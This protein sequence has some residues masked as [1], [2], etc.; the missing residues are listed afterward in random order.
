MVSIN[1]QAIINDKGEIEKVS[2]FISDKSDPVK[3]LD[4]AVCQYVG[5]NRY[6]EFI[7]ANMDNPWVRVIISPS[8]IQMVKYNPN[9]NIRKSRNNDVTIIDGF[10]SFKGIVRRKK[11]KKINSLCT[12]NLR[13]I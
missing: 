13:K 4:D 3:E 10:E 8:L 6:Y 12:E 9:I 2:I 7:D 11:L 1:E 5:D